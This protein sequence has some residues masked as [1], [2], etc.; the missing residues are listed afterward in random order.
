MSAEELSFESDVRVGYMWATQSW[1]FTIQLQETVAALV[2][3]C[4]EAVKDRT[5]AEERFDQKRLKLFEA[6]ILAGT[7]DEAAQPPRK[8]RL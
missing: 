3:D 7:L 4:H 6:A 1:K 2:R 8:S 5:V